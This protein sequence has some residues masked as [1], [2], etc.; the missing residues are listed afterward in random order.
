MNTVGK[1]KRSVNVYS[2]VIGR[3]YRKKNTELKYVMIYIGELDVFLKQKDH[4]LIISKQ[5]F[6]NWIDCK[7]HMYV[8]QVGEVTLPF[9]DEDC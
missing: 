5:D 4:Q 2:G 8:R 1:Q 6:Q 7:H 3:D 9:P